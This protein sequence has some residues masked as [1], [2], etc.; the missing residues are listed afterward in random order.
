MAAPGDGEE[1][2]ERLDSGSGDL[3]AKA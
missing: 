3:F 2:N 1:V